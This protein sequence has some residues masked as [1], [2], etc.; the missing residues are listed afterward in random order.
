M[1]IGKSPY[2]SRLSVSNLYTVKCDKGS[3]ADSRL[4]SAKSTKIIHQDN[5]TS[6]ILFALIKSNL[7][8][9]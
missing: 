3:R 6:N 5:K 4:S 8:F 7:V 9:F 1:K 2:V